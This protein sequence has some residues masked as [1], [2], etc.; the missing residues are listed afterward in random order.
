[1]FGTPP[2]QHINSG[3][4]TLLSNMFQPCYIL[5]GSQNFPT[6]QEVSPQALL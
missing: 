6:P 4:P 2:P 1:M 3:R 5:A